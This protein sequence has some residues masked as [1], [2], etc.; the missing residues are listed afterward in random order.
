[1]TSMF[2]LKVT[3]T[4]P[5]TKSSY[6]LLYVC[7]CIWIV[8]AVLI[9]IGPVKKLFPGWKMQSAWQVI[10]NRPP[11]HGNGRGLTVAI[12]K[13]FRVKP[14]INMARGCLALFD[15]HACEVL[16]CPSPFT[17]H[18]PRGYEDSDFLMQRIDYMS[19]FDLVLWAFER[20]PFSTHQNLWW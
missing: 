6:V 8:K 11:L 14:P 3:V 13:P 1:M 15:P 20:I 16:T 18:Q 12:A 7:R 5:I 2:L 4:R 9:C 19:F 10:V 17:A